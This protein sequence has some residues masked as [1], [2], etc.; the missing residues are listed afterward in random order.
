[1]RRTPEKFTP[2][3]KSGGGGLKQRKATPGVKLSQ[4]GALSMRDTLLT[5][6]PYML[7]IMKRMQQSLAS[8]SDDTI[9]L[10]SSPQGSPVVS[11][12]GDRGNSH[13]APECLPRRVIFEEVG[14]TVESSPAGFPYSN[15][16]RCDEGT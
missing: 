8:F 15:S 1:M 14:D 12:E 13:Q 11:W 9:P 16:G 10:Q 2:R 6:R 4:G 5:T 3:K 7:T